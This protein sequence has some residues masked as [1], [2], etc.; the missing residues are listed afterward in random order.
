[1]II[2]LCKNL[3]CEINYVILLKILAIIWRFIIFLMK[4]FCLHTGLG[5][6]LWHVSSAVGGLVFLSVVA[7]F[8]HKAQIGIRSSALLL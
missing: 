4:I 8:K 2:Y 1:M 7:H 6:G 5:D 3:K